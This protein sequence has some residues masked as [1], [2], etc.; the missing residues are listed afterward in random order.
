[1]TSFTLGVTIRSLAFF[2]L[3]LHEMIKCK[4]KSLTLI[5]KS[6][7]VKVYKFYFRFAITNRSFGIYMYSVAHNQLLQ[8]NRPL[9]PKPRLWRVRW[10][11]EWPPPSPGFRIFALQRY[12]ERFLLYTYMSLPINALE[13]PITIPCLWWSSIRLTAILLDSVTGR[14]EGD[15][16]SDGERHPWEESTRPFHV[17]SNKGE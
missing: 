1:M 4:H 10:M 2:P 12:N 17:V 16:W 7:Y 3:E 5:K 9:D 8:E 11:S 6:T 15:N 14:N 13:A